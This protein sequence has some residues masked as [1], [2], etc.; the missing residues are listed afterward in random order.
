MAQR[1]RV[2]KEKQAVEVKKTEDTTQPKAQDAEA[3]KAET[4][5]LLAEID[6]VLDEV[7][8]QS[9]ASELVASYIQRGG[10]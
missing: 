7:I 3:L 10:Q 6:A 9:T 8:G 5:D 4:D 2:Q 1:E